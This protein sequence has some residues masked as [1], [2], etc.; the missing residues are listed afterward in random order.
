MRSAKKDY[1]EILGVSRTAS[2]KE[3]KAA[4]RRLARKYHPDVNSG[5]KAAEEKFKEVAEAFAVLS[6]SEKRARYDGG[7]HEAFGPDFNPFAG[8]GFDVRNFEFGFGDLSDLF[9]LFTGGRG[10]GRARGGARRGRNL[11]MEIRIPFL[12]AALGTTVDISLPRRGRCE[13]CTGSRLLHGR[14][15]PRCGGEGVAALEDRV[16][17]RIPSGIEDGGKVRIAGKGDAGTAGGPA[18]DAYLIIHVEPHPIF[19]REGRDLYCDLPVGFAKA[20]LG[21]TVEV[22]TLD[23]KTSISIPPGTRSGQK[24]RLKGR[25]IAAPNGNPTGDLYAVIQIHPPK[26]LDRRSRE[27]LEELA[28]IHPD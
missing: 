4:Y 9:D 22:P 16:K 27:L 28:E 26:K 25:G 17:V 24:F 19:R 21:G 10:R 6:D 8:A 18:G 20:A 1:Y 2:D 11:Q 14:P 5:D 23:G 15:C 3:I 7:G 13:T 12:E